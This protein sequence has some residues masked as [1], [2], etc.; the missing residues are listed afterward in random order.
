MRTL[1][2]IQTIKSLEK[3]EG[4]DRILY[5]SFEKVGFRVIVGS[6]SK[7]GD[8]VIYCE[9]DSLLPVRAEF[10][11]LRSR[12]F[13]EKWNGFRIRNMKMGSKY[14]EGLVL[15]LGILPQ[16]DLK[17]QKDGFDVT[18]ILG[19]RKYDP[20]ELEE[21]SLNSKKKK[22]WI[23][24][25]IY[26]I[27]LLRKIWNFFGNIIH[28]KDQKTWPVWASKSDETRAQNLDYIFEKYKGQKWFA[29]EKL[30]GSSMILGY[31]KKKIHV[32][33]RNFSLKDPKKGGD[34]NNYWRYVD[35]SFGR[36]RMKNMRDK[37]G[38]DFY[39][40]GELVGPSIQGNKYGFNRHRFF[41]FNMRNVE[42]GEYLSNKDMRAICSM[43]AF[44]VVPF[45]EDFI[46]NFKAM[47]DLLRYAE[48]YSVFGGKVLR[49]GVVLRPVEIR[50]PDK[51]Q[52]NTCSFK[53]INPSFDL[54]WS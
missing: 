2:T 36:E 26:R 24:T 54:K 50:D 47:P 6:D 46:W 49:E 53:V 18:H 44:E 42:T 15:P 38:Y 31:V 5:A 34:K 51:G 30:D 45:I 12:C 21:Q 32:C 14:S 40:Q 22:S 43:F 25:Q 20:E 7:V 23:R 27:P 29:T 28:P 4:K 17:S 10:E 16:M 19:V 1:A 48:G 35:E 8:K 33:S 41:V 11:F 52:S 39:I 9:V 37:L 13:N 3:I